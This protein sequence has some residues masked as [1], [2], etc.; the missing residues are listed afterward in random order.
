MCFSNMFVKCVCNVLSVYPLSFVLLHMWITA[1]AV[2]QL[3]CLSWQAFTWSAR[4]CEESHCQD[5]QLLMFGELSLIVD[6][7]VRI[8]CYRSGVDNNS[9][10]F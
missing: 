7:K 6:N 2:G 9:E 1:F 10:N 3:A 4:L 5:F 8:F